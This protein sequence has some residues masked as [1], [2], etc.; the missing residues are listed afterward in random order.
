MAKTSKPSLAETHP[1]LSAEAFGWNPFTKDESSK[2]QMDWRCPKG[3]CYK[4]SIQTRIT[5][6]IGCPVCNIKKKRTI[7]QEIK[8]IEKETGQI[9]REVK[10]LERE[11]KRIERKSKGLTKKQEPEITRRVCFSV[12]NAFNEAHGWHPLDVDH[13]SNEWRL[14]KCPSGHV[15]S[16]PVAVRLKYFKSQCPICNNSFNKKNNVEGFHWTQLLPLLVD[17][18]DDWDPLSVNFYSPTIRA[19]RCD[20]KHHFKST[21]AEASKQ[22]GKCF[23]CE[24]WKPRATN[25]GELADELNLDRVEFVALVE[26]QINGQLD[27]VSKLPSSFWDQVIDVLYDESGKARCKPSAKSYDWGQQNSIRTILERCSSCDMLID[28]QREHKCRDY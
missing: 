27:A 18:I 9:N 28:P 14:W 5:A 13:E 6:G 7:E 23:K 10:Q 17:Q 11:I 16:Y 4:E 15:Y 20:R 21:I 19:W 8:Q 25:F 22:Q 1:A 12:A 26:Q 3:H 24:K 2:A